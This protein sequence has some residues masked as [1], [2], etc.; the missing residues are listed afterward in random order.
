[1]KFATK[2]QG[3]EVS[4]QIEEEER[5]KKDQLSLGGIGGDLAPSLGGTEKFVRRPNFRMTSF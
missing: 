4:Q 5:A 3:D 2:A 1:M